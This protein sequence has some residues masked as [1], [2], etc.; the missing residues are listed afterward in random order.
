[1]SHHQMP[2]PTSVCGALIGTLRSRAAAFTSL[3]SQRVSAYQYAARLLSE[4]PFTGAAASARRTTVTSSASASS[5]DIQRL[6]PA[7]DASPSTSA[8]SNPSYATCPQPHVQ[9]FDYTAMAAC[10]AELRRDWVPSKVEQ[11]IQVDPQVLALQLRTAVASGWLYLSWHP[12]LGHLAMGPAPKRRGVASEAFSFGEQVQQATRGL[13]LQEAT[14]PQP[15]ERVALLALAPRL[16]EAPTLRLFCEVMGRYS[17][18]VL[19]DAT[20]GN[21]VLAAGYQVGGKMS[22]LRQVQVGRAYALPPQ[23]PGID[24][25]AC[26]SLQ[27]WR[28]TVV[29]AAA[30]LVAKMQQRA[31]AEALA[32]AMVR[33]FRGVSPS[34]ARELCAAADVAADTAPSALGDAE[35][36]RLWGRWQAWLGAVT[37]GDLGPF[38]RAGDAY[39]V[40]GACGGETSGALELV[41]AYYSSVLASEG[42]AFTKQRLLRAVASAAERLARKVES[43]RRQSGKGDQESATRKL[44]D[45]LMANLY[46]CQPG[47]SS[48]EVEDWDAPGTK[49]IVPLDPTKSAVESAKALYAKARK[50]RR[51]SERVGP[52]IDEA[53]ASLSYLEET[54]VMLGQMSGGGDAEALRE[55]ETEL[56]AGGYVKLVA[57]VVMTEKAASKARKASKNSGKRAGV[58]P[59]AAAVAGCRRYSSPGGLDVLVGRNS[60]QNDDITLKVAKSGDVW[61][62][63]RGVPGAHVLLRVPAG[64][65][66]GDVDLQFAADLAAHFSKSRGSGKVDVTLAD[67]S[68]I[69]KPREF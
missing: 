47:A 58:D 33:A 59:G 19:V 34:L 51:A 6:D 21:H 39:S 69:S 46:V 10:V 37:S 62:H 3:N 49:I 38:G 48:I 44:A 52:M 67:P 24:P 15:W 28:E 9:T 55:V 50:E 64:R 26:E 18:L 4:W 14:L 56:A 40:L 61:M 66:A 17:N 1:M 23:A 20:D 36:Q 57:G 27:D 16:G 54:A 7:R 29:A 53:L 42:F 2:P 22:S 5:P 60:R 12:N 63:A 41:H 31:G 45:L 65:D 11:A 8:P 32:A 35:W 30:V 25:E 43:L 13:V 68:D